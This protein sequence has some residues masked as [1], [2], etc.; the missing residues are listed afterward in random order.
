MP[1]LPL[2]LFTLSTQPCL[3]SCVMFKPNHLS[4]SR[5]VKECLLDRLVQRQ[6]NCCSTVFLRH[7]CLSC[8]SHCPHTQTLS[9]RARLF[10]CESLAPQDYTHPFLHIPAVLP[11]T[12]PLLL[13]LPSSPTARVPSAVCWD[14]RSREVHS[15][16]H[17]IRRREQRYPTHN[18]SAVPYMVALS[19]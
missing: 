17:L 3:C 19:P 6:F 11:K 15:A 14:G 16:C 13:P 1:H 8:S 4:P 12:V 2:M 5:K 9:H 10:S 7:T 18:G